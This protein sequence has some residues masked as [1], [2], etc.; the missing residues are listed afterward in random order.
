MWGQIILAIPRHLLKISIMVVLG[1]FLGMLWLINNEKSL[2][3]F[4]GNDDEIFDFTKDQVHP[5]F[6]QMQKHI[7]KDV[8]TLQAMIERK[9][10]REIGDQ[11]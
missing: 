9:Y 8:Q 5:L 7:V 4:L 6:Y 10:V 11:N 1:S 2:N 3:D